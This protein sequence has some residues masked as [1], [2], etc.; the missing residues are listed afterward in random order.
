MAQYIIK[1]VVT[2][3]LVI[4]VLQISKRNSFFGG[5]LASLPLVSA[6]GMIWLYIDTKDT[7]K[8]AGL[9]RSIFWLVLPSFAFFAVIMLL[10]KAKLNFYVSFGLAAAVLVVCYVA[11]LAVLKRFGVQL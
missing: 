3:A 9:A 11:L 10:L 8:V 4:A 7:V 5:L 2:T 1:V 6:L